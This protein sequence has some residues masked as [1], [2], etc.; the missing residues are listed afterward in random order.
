LIF[1]YRYKPKRSLMPQAAEA[2]AASSTQWSAELWSFRRSYACYGEHA[3]RHP[4][5]WLSGNGNCERAHEIIDELIHTHGVGATR[6]RLVKRDVVAIHESRHA[7]RATADPRGAHK[8]KNRPIEYPSDG[9]PK[10]T[11]PLGASAPRPFRPWCGSL[12]F[13]HA[14]GL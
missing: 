9:V 11:P 5:Q 13:L 4:I 10:N 12:T 6:R 8:V 3:L 14:N 1:C 7:S 2:L